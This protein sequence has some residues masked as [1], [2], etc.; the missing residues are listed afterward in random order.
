M[1][2]QLGR[3]EWAATPMDVT[4]AYRKLSLLVRGRAAE[5]FSASQHLPS[6]HSRYAVASCSD[7]RSQQQMT[8]EASA[9]H[10]VRG[11][12]DSIP[13]RSAWGGIH[14]LLV[15]YPSSCRCA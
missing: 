6:R 2:D 4:K 1:A 15:T 12:G 14:S 9:S 11:C 7:F 3:V 8:C 10:G 13:M 5:L